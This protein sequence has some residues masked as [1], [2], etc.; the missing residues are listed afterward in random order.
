MKRCLRF[1]KLK[2][3]IFVAL[4]Y[5]SGCGEP[6]FENAGS[7]HTLTEDREACATEINKSRAARAYRENPDAHPEYPAYVFTEMN[8]CI[9]RKGWK[10]V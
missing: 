6:T 8:R 7:K 5:L 10:Q 4:T 1:D 9:V 3:A 2:L